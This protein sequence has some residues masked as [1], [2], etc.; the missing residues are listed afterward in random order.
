MIRPFIILVAEF[1]SYQT[2]VP[3]SI[4]VVYEKTL[5]EIHEFFACYPRIWWL[6][7]SIL[8]CIYICV[9]CT[10]LIQPFIVGYMRRAPACFFM[11][12]SRKNRELVQYAPENGPQILT[13]ITQLNSCSNIGPATFGFWCWWTKCSHR[14]R[15]G[16]ASFGC[17]GS[18]HISHIKCNYKLE[19]GVQ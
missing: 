17:K 4:I 5:Y 10:T 2:Y 13:V 16:H 6:F 12:E 3:V 11:Y 19:F 1:T 9:Y 15:A 7:L 14:W 18:I 8:N